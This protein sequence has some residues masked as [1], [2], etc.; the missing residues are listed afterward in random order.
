MD[1]LY[2]DIGLDSVPEPEPA[3][4]PAPSAPAAQ[5]QKE[6]EAEPAAPESK[7]EP[8]PEQTKAATETT[9]NDAAGEE[10]ANGAQEGEANGAQEQQD[11]VQGQGTALTQ[12]APLGESDPSIDNKVFIGGISWESSEDGL[13]MYFDQFGE[14]LEVKIMRDKF[15]GNPRGFGFIEFRDGT[16]VDRATAKRMHTIDRKQ[17]EVKRAVTK[18]QSAENNNKNEEKEKCKLFIGGLPQDCK[19]PDLRAHFE[20]HGTIA[21]VIVMFDQQTGRSRGFGFVTYEDNAIAEKVL[22]MQHEISGKWVDVKKYQARSRQQRQQRQGFGGGGRGGY[23]G[24]Y[25]GYQQQGG[26]GYGGGYQQQGGYGYGGGYQQ[27][28]GGYGYGG[29]QQ[30]QGGYGYGPYGAQ[31]GYDYGGAAYNQG[32]D[33]GYGNY[34]YGGQQQAAY[35]QGAQS[36]YGADQQQQQQQGGYGYGAEQ[37]Q[38]QGG[39]SDSRGAGGGRDKARQ[40]RYRPY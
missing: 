11:Q 40:S 21:D 5:D 35:N 7:S 3:S 36:G 33:Q 1:D 20:K 22:Q 2:G 9:A 18:S 37:A 23:G 19:E 27:Q 34:A 8:L 10:E 4:A 13:K 15:T 12:S 31:G 6:Q 28:Q 32:A 26:Y 16:G 39:G 17:V 38:Q 25:G 30:Q 29:Y 24:G 14:V